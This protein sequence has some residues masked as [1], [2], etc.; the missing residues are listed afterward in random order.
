MNIYIKVVSMIIM[1]KSVQNFPVWTRI[2]VHLLKFDK[3]QYSKFSENMLGVF[4]VHLGSNHWTI[5]LT[6]I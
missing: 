3:D 4:F 5:S 2:K 6:F 1:V